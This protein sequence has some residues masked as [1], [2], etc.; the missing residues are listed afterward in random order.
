MNKVTLL[1][2]VGTNFS[3]TSPFHYTVSWDH[4]CVYSGH[5]KENAYLYNLMM[6]DKPLRQDAKIANPVIFKLP[7]IKPHD[8]RIKSEYIEGTIYSGGFPSFPGLGRIRTMCK[9]TNCVA[10]LN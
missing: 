5:I 4:K 2:N 3:A 8:L 7:S 9:W 6:G 10:T 1:L